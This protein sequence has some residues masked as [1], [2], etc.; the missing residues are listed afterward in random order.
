MLLSANGKILDLR[1]PQIMGILNMTPDSFSDGGK[2][3][4]LDKA[5]KKVESMILSGAT[6][7]DVGG[8]S[9][10]PGA[11]DVSINDEIARVIPLV[12]AIKKHFDVW[13]SLDTSK[14]AV[15]QEGIIN[16]VD[17][18][19][20][21]RALR[22]PGTLD[23]VAASNL[24][25]CLMHMQ[26]QP[27]TMQQN[28]IYDDVLQD[29]CDFLEKRIDVCEKAGVAK[30]NIILDP[31]FGFGKSV[32]HNYHLLANLEKFHQ[33][34]LPILA[35]MSRKSMIS[36]LLKKTPAESVVGSVVCA[37]IAAQK[38]AQIIRVHDVAETQDAM[39]VLNMIQCNI[40]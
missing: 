20:D 6:I 3:N 17:I 31:G 7:I 38:G 2:F 21:I 39:R 8:E 5:M 26:G 25:V 34:G 27:R 16:G 29:V 12:C 33:Y 28:P 10:R 11:Q 36:K 19:N 15:M 9:T 1:T 22:E 37:T 24:P 18:I 14:A 32:E 30:K 40:N 35:G 13:V 23:V 4:H